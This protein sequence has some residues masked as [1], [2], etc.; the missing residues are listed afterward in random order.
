MKLGQIFACV[1]FAMGLA[2]CD[3]FKKLPSR[4]LEFSCEGLATPPHVEV[5]ALNKARFYK[6]RRES[7]L[8]R[9]LRKYADPPRPDRKQTS[10]ELLEII[11]NVR[12]MTAKTFENSILEDSSKEFSEFSSASDE[13]D[14][15]LLILSGGGQWGAFGATFLADPVNQ[16]DWD[17]VTGISTGALQALFVGAGNYEGLVRAYTVR[18]KN[19]LATKPF[20]GPLRYGGIYNTQKLKARLIATLLDDL[21]E[22]GEPNG[23]AGLLE[24]IAMRDEGAPAKRPHIYIGALEASTGHF[25]EID[26][27]QMVQDHYPRTEEDYEEKR[28]KLAECVAGWSLGSSAVPVQLLPVRITESVVGGTSTKVYMDGGVRKSAFV[29]P[30]IFADEAEYALLT[31]LQEED[32]RA[33][34]VLEAQPADDDATRKQKD[35]LQKEAFAAGVCL[36]GRAES[37]PLKAP[38]PEIYVVRNGPT[39]VPEDGHKQIVDRKPGVYNTAMRAYATLVNENELSS[40]STI[41]LEYPRRP[42]QFVSADSFNWNRDVTEDCRNRDRDTKT[43]FDPAFMACLRDWGRLHSQRPSDTLRPSGWR[44]IRNERVCPKPA[45]NAD[46]TPGDEFCQEEADPQLQRTLA[47]LAQKISNMTKPEALRR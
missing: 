46:G 16:R 43:Y 15:K 39:W 19:E 10:E 14:K 3:Q 9:N 21:D 36:P 29:A 28:A 25:F 42:L 32:R 11:A 18:E 26:I 8:F 23:G 37:Q 17:Y 47:P 12:G 45:D 24:R 22:N 31:A 40:L 6:Q 33:C 27:T 38:K 44:E 4:P 35:Q 7:Y 13:P 1:L 5:S 2:S 34:A 41:L 30:A 20:I